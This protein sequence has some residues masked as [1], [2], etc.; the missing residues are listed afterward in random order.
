MDTMELPS[1]LEDKQVLVKFLAA[2][3]NPADFNTIEGNYA[4]L[5]KQFPAIAGNEGVAVV[6]AVG[7]NSS[8]KPGTRVIPA[9]PAFGTWRTHA[10]C[11][12][13]DLQ[14]IS[15]KIPLEYAAT[16]AVNP[17]TAYR[18]LN[19]FVELKEGDVIVQNGATS[20]VGQTV[21]QLARLRG[22][23]TINILRNLTLD[24]QDESV[25]RL[26]ALG[27]DIV[28]SEQYA[29]SAAMRTLISDLPKP[30]LALNCVG[31]SSARVT[32]SLLGEKGVMVTYGGMSRQPVTLPTGPF[33]FKDITLRGFW[34]S[35][36][37]QTHS[38]Q[39]RQAMM[40]EIADLIQK[41]KMILH[42]HV[43]KFEEY[44]RAIEASLLPASVDRR[45]IVMLMD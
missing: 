5:P 38:E 42:F 21:I 25:E 36:W 27:G 24:Q 30:K 4:I 9:K 18:L 13:S 12:D 8:L 34:I 31:G 22:I 20:M 1:K 23:K 2:P 37:I 32:A 14:T 28:V 41:R 7:P 3:I 45:K 16:L 43:F 11:A 26:K 19:D 6:E 39:E 10:V 17:C 40:N 29:N 35:K 15:D 44:Y 33:I